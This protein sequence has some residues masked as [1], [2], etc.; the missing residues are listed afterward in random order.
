VAIQPDPGITPKTPQD[1]HPLDAETG[2]DD[3]PVKRV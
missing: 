3:G 2:P 1:P